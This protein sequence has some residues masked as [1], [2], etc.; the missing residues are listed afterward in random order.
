[1]CKLWGWS[2][3]AG[4]VL[5]LSLSVASTVVLLKALEERNLVN[6][7]SG[8]VAVGWSPRPWLV[9]SLALPPR[10]SASAGSSTSASTITRSS[11]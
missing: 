4:I 6:A 3:G 10:S 8:R 1:L 2:L 11:T 5:G 9:V 7:A